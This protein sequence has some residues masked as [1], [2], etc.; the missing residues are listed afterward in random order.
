M[1]PEKDKL[2]VNMREGVDKPKIICEIGV[3][4]LGDPGYADE[5]I[6]TL[7][8]MG[9]DGVTFQMPEKAW[10]QR[11][12]NWPRLDDKYYETA[13]T[14]TRAAKIKFGIALA[15][16]DEINFFEELGVDFYKILSKDIG[17]K[18]LMA[19]VLM[20][21][22][23]VFVSTGMSDMEGVAT[24]VEKIGKF[25]DQI[26]LIHTQLTHNLDDANL[27]AIGIMKQRFGLPVAFG[28]HSLNPNVLYV[29]LGLEPSHLFFYVRGSRK[30][31]HGDEG[32]AISLSE[33]GNIISNLRKLSLTLGNG[34]KL[35]ITTEEWREQQ[36]KE[37]SRREA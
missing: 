35:K 26:T 31:R 14:K 30:E 33:C 6:D 16:L 20:A 2:P 18:E 12:P 3:N 15:D 19:E 22:R 36:K 1:I 37:G 5:Y 28:Y 7:L 17:N 9:P 34:E 8:A 10:Y 4:H 24:F 23:P 21:G 11:H 29:A 13:A 25:K 32:H 27:K